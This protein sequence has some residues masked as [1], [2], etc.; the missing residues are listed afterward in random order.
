M[1]PENREAALATA[2]DAEAAP[3][4]PAPDPADPAAAPPLPAPISPAPGL[5]LLVKGGF[6]LEGDVVFEFSEAG[7]GLLGPE[8]VELDAGEG[9]FGPDDVEFELSGAGAELLG[10]DAGSGL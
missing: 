6:G 8:D 9:F 3:P 5:V 1:L 10:P 2:P 7:T 4:A